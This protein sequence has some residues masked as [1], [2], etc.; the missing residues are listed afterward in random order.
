MM[1]RLVPQV[2]SPKR[3]RAVTGVPSTRHLHYTLILRPKQGL[4][5][6]ISVM[7]VGKE[8]WLEHR[9]P[10]V[11]RLLPWSSRAPG[12]IPL[13]TVRRVR[14]ITYPYLLAYI[15]Q[16]KQRPLPGRTGDG[17]CPFTKVDSDVREL[18]GLHLVQP[19]PVGSTVGHKVVCAHLLEGLKYLLEEVRLLIQQPMQSRFGIEVE[20][21]I[22]RHGRRPVEEKAKGLV[23]VG[24]PPHIGTED[25]GCLA[26]FLA[27]PGRTVVAQIPLVD[28]FLPAFL[29]VLP[30]DGIPVLDLLFRQVA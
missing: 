30:K 21:G 17:L 16:V 22:R 10:T 1:S 27:V 3:L 9:G 12:W 20:V 23:A 11:L 15:L 8:D 26:R 4:V 29:K 5:W 28:A 24:R 7:N 2:W 18:F 19:A 13:P 14:A 6:S 25:G